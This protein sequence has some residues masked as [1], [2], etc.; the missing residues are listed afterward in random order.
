MLIADLLQIAVWR[1]A[2]SMTF[3]APHDDWRRTTCD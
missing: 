3:L 1:I 2:D